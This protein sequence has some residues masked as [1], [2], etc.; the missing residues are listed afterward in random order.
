[1]IEA[2]LMRRRR[3]TH[4]AQRRQQPARLR[5]PIP[6]RGGRCSYVAAPVVLDGAAIGFFHGDYADRH[7]ESLDRDA[8][9]A[10]AHG[11]AQVFERAVLRRR[12][13]EQR[14]QLRQ[15]VAWADAMAGELSD[16]AIEL[17]VEREPAGAAVRP[18][19]LPAPAPRARA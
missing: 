13:R 1:M 4:R 12:L 19:A 8:V 10:F 7:V 6:V 15:L 2:E 9:W 5:P 14:Q 3:A 11:F 17:E 18:A 16:G